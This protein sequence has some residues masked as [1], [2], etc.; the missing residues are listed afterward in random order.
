MKKDAICI[1]F[2]E[3]VRNLRKAK[4]VSQEEFADKVGIHRTYIG[5]IERGERNPTLTTIQR[6]AESLGVSAKDLL[7]ENF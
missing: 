5:G 2:G 4:G 3:T 7:P 1:A 6:I